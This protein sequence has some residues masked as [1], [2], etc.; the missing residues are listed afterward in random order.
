MTLAGVKI[1]KRCFV[2]IGSLVMH[3]IPDG[4]T[5]VGRPA[6]ELEEFKRQR[7][8]LKELLQ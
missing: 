5:V 4:Q 8:R 2:G 1:G 3:D 6:M 7:K